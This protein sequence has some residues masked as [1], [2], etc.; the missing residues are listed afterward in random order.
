MNENIHQELKKLQDEL[1]HLKSAID[2][3]NQAKDASLKA[4]KA[5]EDIIDSSKLLF[6]EYNNLAIETKELVKRIEAIDFPQY[7]E[8]IEIKLGLINDGIQKIWLYSK[9]G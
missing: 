7:L 9:K 5:A 3:I 1:I 4:V 6:E 2:Q 8:K